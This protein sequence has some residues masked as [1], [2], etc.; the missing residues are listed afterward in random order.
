MTYG[1]A[2]TVNQ[3]PAYLNRIYK[4]NVSDELIAD[5]RRRYDLIGRSPLIA[6]T[7]RQ[8]VLLEESLGYDFVTV[9]KE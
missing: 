7:N 6:I 8:A 2:T 4:G 3:V 1:S 9:G 5:F